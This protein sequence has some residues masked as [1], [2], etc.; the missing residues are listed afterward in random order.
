MTL[1][2]RNSFVPMTMARGIRA[3]MRRAPDKIAIRHGQ[4]RLTYRDLAR[5]ID[6]A[7]NAAI[8]QPG[9][10]QGQNVAIV[11]KNRTEYFEV[12]CGLPEAGVAVA[13]V[14][15]RVTPAEV[16]A[17]CDDADAQIVFADSECAAIVRSARAKSVRRVIEFGPDYEQ[18]LATGDDAMP[19]REISEVDTWTIPY[20]SGTTGKPKGVMISHRSRSLA[21]FISATEYG[22]FSCDDRFLAM[23][24]LNHGGGLAF[25]IGALL[26]GAA[27]EL[28]DKFAAGPVMDL[29]ERGGIT[30]VFMVPTHFH[31]IFELPAA[32]LAAFRPNGLRAIICNAAP[33][34]QA[35]KEKIIALFGPGI[36]HELYG[37][38]EAGMVANLRPADQLRKTRCVGPP[39]TQV[40]F[41]I[42]DDNG[43][44]C[45]TGM[46]GEIF[47]R[48]PMLFS[49]YWNRPTETTEAIRGGWVTVG[50]MGRCDDEGFLY[51]VDRKKDMVISGGVNIYPREIEEVLASHPD[52][53]EAAVVGVPDERWGE[54]LKAF[55][56]LRGAKSPDADAIAQHCANKLASF[57]IPREV[58][59]IDLLPRN[60]NGKVLKTE[61]RKL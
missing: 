51:I 49:G 33:L 34:S 6:A 14:N 30:G 41:G 50:D 36:L 2:D 21:G 61:L 5:R 32:R 25:P 19:A 53:L 39:M 4:V 18:W 59:A 46:V 31:S 8:A 24:P 54:R 60:S 47:V 58:I 56:V 42:L 55:V 48:S 15:P 27:V 57:K 17:I 12:V 16:A 13:T 22:C 45:A 29:F 9:L 44:N 26:N 20:T 40:E 35:Y 11:S 1:P 10:R 38:T 37:S 7:I 28:L 3:A 43:R 52:I 23:T